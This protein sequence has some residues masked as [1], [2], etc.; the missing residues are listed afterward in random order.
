MHAWGSYIHG[1]DWTDFPCVP[2]LHLPTHCHT[3]PSCYSHG[4]NG[5]CGSGAIWAK[6]S[7]YT[8]YSLIWGTSD[9]CQW[10]N[11]AMFASDFDVANVLI[12][13]YYIFQI[14]KIIIWTSFPIR[15]LCGMQET[16]NAYG[17][18]LSIHLHLYWPT[19]LLNSFLPFVLYTALWTG[20]HLILRDFLHHHYIL[21][22][23]I[24]KPSWNLSDTCYKIQ[25]LQLL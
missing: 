8:V 4:V 11:Y 15:L 24:C 6:L 18:P 14:C 13:K 7:L 22:A 19:Q 16:F 12:F 25:I 3:V 20:L 1:P 23:I 5:P 10:S 21:A 17:P 9:Q 2:F